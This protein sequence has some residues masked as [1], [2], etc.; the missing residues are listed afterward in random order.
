M[1]SSLDAQWRIAAIFFMHGFA[2]AMLHTR[3]PDLQLVAGLNDAGLGLVL[4]GAPLGSMAMFPLASPLIE[5]FG[6]RRVTFAA[7]VIMLLAIPAMPFFASAIPLFVLLMAN[8]AGSSLS[9]MTFNV[10]ADRVEHRIGRRVMNSCH[11]AWSI[12]YLLASASGAAIRGAAVPAALHLGVLTVGIA[13]AALTLIATT[14]PAPA[15][16][17]T[18][19]P[20]R[21]RFALPSL[22]LLSLVAVGLGAE[23]LEGASRIWATILLRDSFE[24]AAWIESSALPA[25]VVAMAIGRLV[26]D[27]WIDRFGPAAVSRLLLA[28]AIVGLTMVTTAFHP[29]LVIIGFAITGAGI[30]VIYPLSISAA[31]RLGDGP[32]SQ[33]VATLTLIIQLVMLF[34]PM[35]T[36]FIA[37]QWGVRAAFGALIPLLALGWLM[38]GSLGSKTADNALSRQAG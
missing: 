32:A 18:A 29:A 15:R 19:S 34:A 30:C 6:T 17:F 3:I 1:H 21:R 11:G 12:G 36:G 16:A 10:E 37:R 33:N 22:V 38:A 14:A 23:L 7:F 35:M 31:A 28:L 27:R 5:R 13:L 9:A 20:G 25:M 24:V 8:G 4:M 2:N 26:A